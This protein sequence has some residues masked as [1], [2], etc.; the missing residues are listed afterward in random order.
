MSLPVAVV[1]L[2]ADADAQASA[3]RSAAAVRDAARGGARLVVLPEYASGWAPQ[4]TADLAQGPD[5]PFQTAV[6]A[7]AAEAQVWVVAGTVMPSTGGRCE[8]VALLIGPDGAVAGQYRK[9]HLFDAFGVRESEVL[10]GGTPGGENVLTVDIGGLRVGIATCYD[11]RFPESFR[12]LADAGADVLV[13]I[14]AWADGPGK[15]DQLDV[16]ARARA[17]ENTCYLLLASQ[18]GE[19]RVGRSA[20]IEPLGTVMDRGG[21]GDDVILAARLEEQVVADARAKVPSLQHRQFH[22]R[23]GPPGR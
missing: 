15:A 19:G 18:P 6:R 12:L 22:V 5:G 14:A 8:N 17:L 2:A 11:L 10:D 20:L 13:V 16:L 1:Q 23:P 21:A 7:A 4:I 9:V 3:R